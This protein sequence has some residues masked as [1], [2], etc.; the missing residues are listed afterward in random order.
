MRVRT[1]VREYGIRTTLP[2]EQVKQVFHRHV[3]AQARHVLF[4]PLEPSDD[5][6]DVPPT[7]AAVASARSFTGGWAVQIHIEDRGA[8]RDVGLRVIGTRTL[9]KIMFGLR[10]AYLLGKGVTVA[11]GALERLDA[12]GGRV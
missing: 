9:D 11:E 12:A 1:D 7:F 10:D 2:V 3:S 6:F 5:P 8:V 4:E